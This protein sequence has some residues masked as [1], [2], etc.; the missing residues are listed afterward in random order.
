MLPAERCALLLLAAGGSE[1]FGERD[2]LVEPFL[3]RPLALHVVTA[4]EAIPF[5]RREAVLGRTALDLAGEGYQIVRNAAPEEGQSRSLRLGVAAARG[6]DL[7]AIVVVL[8]DL[9]RVTATQVYRLIDAA[10]D[11]DAV[12]ASSDGKRPRPPA[13][14]GAAHFDTLEA[15]TGDKGARDLIV[16]G[17]HIVTSPAELVDIDTPEELEALRATYELGRT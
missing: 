15:Q 6:P 3:G 9:P 17:R 2:K 13:L 8:A 4:L 7:V 10:E 1:R 16:A 12:L 5:A 11:I 14:F